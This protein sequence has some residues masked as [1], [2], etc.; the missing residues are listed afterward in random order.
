MP[1]LE[2][3][4]WSLLAVAAA[5]DV[6][7]RRIPNPVV[8]LVA[9]SGLLARW[10]EGGPG[11]ALLA[12]L[13]AAG[14]LLVLLVPW[15]A[16]KIGGGDVKLLAATAIWMGPGR[17]LPFL[18]LTAVAGAPVALASRPSTVPYAVAVGLGAFAAFHGVLP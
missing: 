17:L 1:V 13:A 12:V 9:V 7:Q 15:T 16:G 11:P 14:T 10:G 2:P 8:L 18:A 6:A 3:V 5:A 4:L